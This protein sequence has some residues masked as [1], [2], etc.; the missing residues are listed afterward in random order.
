MSIIMDARNTYLDMLTDRV[1][2]FEER[3][4]ELIGN[5]P[6]LLG[7]KK[8][9]DAVFLEELKGKLSHEEAVEKS[10]LLQKEFERTAKEKGLSDSV[11]DYVPLCPVCGDTGYV[12]GRQCR[13]L[14]SYVIRSCSDGGNLRD[15][16]YTAD[17]FDTG[18]YSKP[19]D[20]ERAEKIRLG[21]IRYICDFGKSFS[22]I[23]LAGGPGSGKSLL[24][25][26]I[27]DELI[28]KEK[29][30]MHMRAPVLIDALTDDIYE[31]D[32]ENFFE[33]AV[34]CDFLVIDDLGTERQTD[35]VQ[36]RLFEVFD[37]RYR[38]EKPTM[39]TTNLSAERQREMYGDRIF[40][41][42]YSKSSFNFRMPDED[43]RLKLAK[44][45]RMKA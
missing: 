41:R 21:V 17:D 34:S 29:T 39:I 28:G 19:E 40:S 38:R 27:C 12:N 11:L 10:E 37:E 4:A 42:F 33:M 36:N 7:K 9:V 16:L 20:R 8:A 44:M 24:S 30:V 32:N 5:D 18:I 26:I 22:N 2:S 45:E 6:L 14:R 31:D 35:F 1:R 23:A 13:C 43:I 25:Y 15:R 3:K